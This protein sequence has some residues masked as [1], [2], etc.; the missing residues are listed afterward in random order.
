MNFSSIRQSWGLPKVRQHLQLSRISMEWRR[1][2]RKFIN[3]LRTSC[4]YHHHQL[5]SS[6]YTRAR[7][8]D[9]EFSLFIFSSAPTQPPAI[10]FHSSE[11]GERRRRR[12]KFFHSLAI[13]KSSIFGRM[14]CVAFLE[15]LLYIFQVSIYIE[16]DG[17]RRR[18]TGR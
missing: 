12:R 17:R 1:L 15:L 3:F 7:K 4:Q 8:N 6:V 18:G 16:N 14:N 11:R 5:K 2:K 9:E 10:I 13:I